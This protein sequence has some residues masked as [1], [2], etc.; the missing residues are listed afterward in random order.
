MHQ[1]VLISGGFYVMLITRGKTFNKEGSFMTNLK[2]LWGAGIL[3]LGLVCSSAV[4]AEEPT[5]KKFKTVPA[6]PII[7]EEVKQRI[8][9]YCNSFGEKMF[10]F[11]AH[12]KAGVSREMSLQHY[13]LDAEINNKMMKMSNQEEKVVPPPSIEQTVNLHN[14]IYSIPEEHFNDMNVIGIVKMNVGQ[15]MAS[16]YR[17]MPNMNPF[18]Q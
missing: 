4:L 16:I 8:Q 7:S 13:R 6:Q 15:C 5:E 14:V 3:S 11:A 12:R 17:Q 10:L 18:S 2:K 1:R 9:N